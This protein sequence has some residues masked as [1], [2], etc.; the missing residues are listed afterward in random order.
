MQDITKEIEKQQRKENFYSKIVTAFGL[1]MVA[2]TA[3]CFATFDGD[4]ANP[5]TKACFGI[6]LA[7]I[8][9]G[10][11]AETKRAIAERRAQKLRG[12]NQR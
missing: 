11:V 8:P 4:V 1:L 10:I 5:A 12:G 7:A 9:F 3:A 6:W 2:D